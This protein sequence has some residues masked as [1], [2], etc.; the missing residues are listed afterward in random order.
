MEAPDPPDSAVIKREHGTLIWREDHP[1]AG[2]VVAKRYRHRT[3]WAALR[4]RL[5]RFRVER[6]YHRLRYLDRAGIPVTEP[7]GWN[8]GHSSREG[9]HETL[10]MREV[11]DAVPLDRFLR[12]TDK[13]PDLAPLYRILR[14]L[15]EAGFCHQT[16][17]TQNVLIRPDAPPG[18]AYVLLDV[19]RS[20]IFPESIVGSSMA[21][22]DLLDLTLRIEAA[23][24]PSA[25]IPL[26]AYGLTT[27]DRRWWQR[28][29]DRNP[30]VKR[31]RL[32]RDLV[33]RLR[34]GGGWLVSPLRRG[35][36]RS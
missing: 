33:A 11:A 4:E 5:T 12:A 8:H 7:L 1:E 29:R 35:S 14:D 3:R 13:T 31:A 24:V 25:K 19:P 6:E 18:E 23:G 27:A 2:P 9:F 15:H 34:W 20:W 30:A 17:Y 36:D 10:V 32:R 16:F 22:Y 28:H 26:E 21:R